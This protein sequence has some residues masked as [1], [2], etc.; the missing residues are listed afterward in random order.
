MPEI[1]DSGAYI[2]GVDP[3]AIALVNAKLRFRKQVKRH[4]AR[5]LR[6]SAEALPVSSEDFTKV[7]SLNAIYFWSSVE[8]AALEFARV[9]R[10]GG[11][12][13]VGFARPERLD[14]GKRPEAQFQ[15]RDP[16][17]VA[18]RFFAAGFRRPKIISPPGKP[19]LV[20]VIAAKPWP[21][22]DRMPQK[23]DRQLPGIFRQSNPPY[24]HRATYLTD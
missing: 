3:A 22:L 1:L 16:V 2:C 23:A 10:P 18:D 15:R 4:H 17:A 21:A 11:V 20:L 24:Q 6:D 8:A 12:A 5:F 13:A 14:E 7:L 9:L 19:W